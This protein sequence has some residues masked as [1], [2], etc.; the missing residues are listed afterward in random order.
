MIAREA[1]AGSPVILLCLRSIAQ[2]ASL[3][4]NRH[5]TAQHN[6]KAGLDLVRLMA[7][8]QLVVEFQFL[9][10]IMDLTEETVLGCSDRHLQHAAC[11]CIHEVL[12]GS[13]DYTRKAKCAFWYQHLAAQADDTGP[14]RQ[15]TQTKLI[16]GTSSTA[17]PPV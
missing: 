12:T 4:L 2:K 16:A 15:Q 6:A 10:D 11:D 7:Q 1:A 3:L 8:M 9:S 5:S 13:D 17:V 14:L